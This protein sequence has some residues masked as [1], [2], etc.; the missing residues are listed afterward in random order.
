MRF[1]FLSASVAKDLE[2]FQMDQTTLPERFDLI[3]I[4]R[5]TRSVYDFRVD[6]FRNI[7]KLLALVCPHQR[8]QLFPTCNHKSLRT[9]SEIQYH[10]CKT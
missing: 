1:P 6:L 4:G 10:R 5:G 2:S 7:I 9:N 8:V 3:Q